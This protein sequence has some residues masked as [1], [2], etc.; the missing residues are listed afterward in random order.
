MPVTVVIGLQWGDEGKGRIVDLQ[1]KRA[2]IVAR[3]NAGPNAG[4]TVVIDGKKT[5]LH[6][7]PAGIFQPNTTC[8]IANGTVVDPFVLV[9]ELA[10]L[11]QARIALAGRLWVSP[12]CHLIMP[13]HK[14]LDGLHEVA[15]GSGRTGTT[16]RGIGPAHADKV[17]YL[18]LRVGD[19]LRPALL[20]ERLNVALGIKNRAVASLGGTTYDTE[21]LWS[22]LQGVTEQLSPYIR[23]TYPIIQEAITQGRMLLMAGANGVLLDND[24]GTY[25]FCTAATTL[26]SGVGQGAGI[27]PRHIDH[28]FGVMKAYMT[29]VGAGPFPTEQAND[30]GEYIRKAGNE[31]GATTGRPRRCGWFDGPLT[32]FAVELNGCDQA[33]VTKLD[34]LDGLESLRL[35]TAYRLDGRLVRDFPV[36]AEDLTR[37]EVMYE[38]MPGWREST[39]AARRYSDLPLAARRYVERIEELSGVAITCITVGAERN[40]II[41]RSAGSVL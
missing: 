1:S 10:E 34:V 12:R 28:V 41:E 37:L 6:M 17:S 13:Y 7:V 25:P 26:A 3:Y 38:D 29:R 31:F 14:Q 21:R 30:S 22:D 11:Q 39:T 24:F 5:V 40:A 36:D 20:R 19:L 32:R 16:G 35:A 2:D 9:G 27:A 8:L 33:A 18:G 23:E 15:K 4:H